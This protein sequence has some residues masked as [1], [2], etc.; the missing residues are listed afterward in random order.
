VADISPPE[1]IPEVR[2]AFQILDTA[3]DLYHRLFYRGD[4]KKTSSVFN[5]KE[6]FDVKNQYGDILD[7]DT[8]AWKVDPFVTLSPKESTVPLYDSYDAAMRFAARP[9]CTLQEYIETW[10][11]RPLAD[12][13]EDGTVKGEHTSFYSPASDLTQ[14]KGAVFWGRI[15][16]LVQGP[17]T[18]PSVEVTNMGPSPDYSGAGVGNNTF[19]E[20]EQGMPQTRQDW[21]R[22]LEE[23]RKIIRREEGRIAPLT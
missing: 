8:E 12:L 7:L 9:A 10:H 4:P 3:N 22:K 14:T 11:G 13:L 6:M 16:K 2:E 18:Q 1:V 23:Y 15:Y 19:V 20:S 17:G 5:W 21:D